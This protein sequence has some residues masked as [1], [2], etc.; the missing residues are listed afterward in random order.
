MTKLLKGI[1]SNQ[2]ADGGVDWCSCFQSDWMT[3]LQRP[4]G[5]EATCL[6]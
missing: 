1:I 6:S 4:R 2:K 5:F 3:S